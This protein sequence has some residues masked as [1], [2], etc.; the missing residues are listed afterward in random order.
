MSCVSATTITHVPKPWGHS[1]V[2]EV[3]AQGAG[4]PVGGCGGAVGALQLSGLHLLCG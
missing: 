4:T 2:L 1:S 3:T